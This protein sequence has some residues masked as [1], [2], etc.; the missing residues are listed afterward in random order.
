MPERPSQPR[1]VTI[2][3]TLRRT[4]IRKNDFYP[5]RID[6]CRLTSK[7][8]EVGK[9][10][11]ETRL[12]RCLAR[13][14]KRRAPI[15]ARLLMFLWIAQQLKMIKNAWECE[16]RELFFVRV[17][18]GVKEVVTLCPLIVTAMFTL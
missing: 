4:L 15:D 11:D 1:A 16:V 10:R 8:G 18:C 2:L 13:R 7:F 17:Q 5:I 9:P 14:N 12:P 3:H 6:L